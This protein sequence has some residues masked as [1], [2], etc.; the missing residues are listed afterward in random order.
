[1]P[2]S[3]AISILIMV[4]FTVMLGIYPELGLRIVDPVVSFM[5]T[6]L[7]GG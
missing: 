7:G 2:V 1:V 4:I 6:S 5:M 3:M